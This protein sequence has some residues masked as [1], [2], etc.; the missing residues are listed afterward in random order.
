MAAL[1]VP[2]FATLVVNVVVPQSDVVGAALPVRTHDGSVITMLSATASATLSLK[3]TATVVLAPAVGLAI[4]IE[5]S[6]I[7]AGTVAVEDEIEVADMDPEANV[8][9]IV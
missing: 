5:V 6:L 8:P 9:A 4:T 7:F 2:L 1:A 3:E